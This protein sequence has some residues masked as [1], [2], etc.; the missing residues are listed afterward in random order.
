VSVGPSAEHV[1]INAGGLSA[2][3]ATLEPKR[4]TGNE[5]PARSRLGAGFREPS[6][7]WRQQHTLAA[8]DQKTVGR[9]KGSCGSLT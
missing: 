1:A 3:S 9:G 7:S 5:N 6:L 2:R 4:R 8:S